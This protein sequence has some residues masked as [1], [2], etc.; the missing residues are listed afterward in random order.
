MKDLKHRLSLNPVVEDLISEHDKANEA[1][2]FASL[3]KNL[4]FSLASFLE[5]GEQYLP[6]YA[7]LEIWDYLFKETLDSEEGLRV[8]I[9]H[10][11]TGSGNT[12]EFE[13]NVPHIEFITQ[14]L[15][16]GITEWTI[17]KLLEVGDFDGTESLKDP[18]T[19]TVKT[20]REWASDFIS[21]PGHK[22]FEPIIFL[23]F[24]TV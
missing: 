11:K 7:W 15:R 1:R 9:S 24:D 8:E 4:I 23:N 21:Y 16:H 20:S 2:R 14:C 3:H 12:E 17:E 10:L 22:L 13:I 19:S 6:T 18:D 5:D